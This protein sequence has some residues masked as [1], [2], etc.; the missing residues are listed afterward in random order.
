[1][2]LNSPLLGLSIS[3]GASEFARLGPTCKGIT[4]PKQAIYISLIKE[5]FQVESVTRPSIINWS[6][7][8]Y[9]RGKKNKKATCVG[10]CR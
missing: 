2:G 3:G 5:N 10:G 1:V 6:N 4:H 7:E 8:D 9:I